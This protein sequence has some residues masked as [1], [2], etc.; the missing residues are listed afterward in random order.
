MAVF[1][2]LISS[3]NAYGTADNSLTTSVIDNKRKYAG[4]A[5]IG[6]KTV[7]SIPPIAATKLSPIAIGIAGKTITLASSETI[8]ICPNVCTVSGK[9]MSCADEVSR[10]IC[11]K[12]G[13][14]DGVLWKNLRE[15][16]GP[17]TKTPKN[18]KKLN[19]QPISLHSKIGDSIAVTTPLNPS[20][21]IGRAARP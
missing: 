15:N 14:S 1:E 11:P 18:A 6:P 19:H 7:L 17:I 16:V 2:K 4:Q 3:T 13:S 8:E 21:I 20:N 10:I 9:V 12:K 5:T